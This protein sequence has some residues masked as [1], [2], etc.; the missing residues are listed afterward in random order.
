MGE[1]K[2]TIIVHAFDDKNE[3]NGIGFGMSGF[4]VRFGDEIHCSKDDPDA[5]MKKNDAHEITFELADRT[6]KGLLFP[7]DKKLAMWV[8]AND[9]DCP[10]SARHRDGI[11]AVKV[12]DNREQLTVHNSNKVKE[13][14]KFALNFVAADDAAQ[15][16]IIQFDPV[17][18]N[19]NG[20]MS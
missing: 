11:V 10:N 1:A 13:R 20:G 15:N 2:R 7:T 3:P 12:S 6:T 9:Q 19:Q 14:L 8:S 5:R 17:W 18:A 16:K 4:G